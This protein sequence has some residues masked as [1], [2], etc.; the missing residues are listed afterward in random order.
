[1]KEPGSGGTKHS[2]LG[3]GLSFPEGPAFDGEGNLWCVELAAG[4]LWH[5][6][7]HGE[8]RR[9]FVDGRPNGI[10]LDYHG[11]VWFCD[12]GHNAIRLLDPATN[13]VWTVVDSLRGHPLDKPNDLAFDRLGNLVFTCPGDSR[14]EPTGYACALAS[15]GALSVIASAL[16]FP[17]GLAFT[18]DDE[19]L[20]IAETRRQR[21]WTGCWEADTRTW[22]NPRVLA[23][24]AG[25][26]GP[27]GLALDA[28]GGIYVAV[29]GS[30]RIQ[31]KT[32]KGASAG[33]LSVG[34]GNPTN[35]AFDPTGRLGLVVTEA[36]HG[37]VLSFA[38]V[39]PGLPVSRPARSDAVIL[40]QPNQ[41]GVYGSALAANTTAMPCHSITPSPASAEPP[42][43]KFR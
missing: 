39:G 40:P 17:N 1:M 3:A 18:R 20:L 23:T 29:H 5:R 41:A 16:Y 2:V 31:I 4:M 42:R 11:R 9:H 37:A 25:Q 32:F 7:V 35:C 12:S 10:A 8:V 36:A 38:D 6:S 33:S 19:A 21:I 28:A 34:T 26:I 24:T 30:N 27:D 22:S 13:K 43:T 15:D 14:T